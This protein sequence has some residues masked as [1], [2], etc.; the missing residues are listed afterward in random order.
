MIRKLLLA[1]AAIF[2]GKKVIAAKNRQGGTAFA[3]ATPR[4]TTG[5]HV[6]TDLMGDTHPGF[7]QRAPE[8]FRPDPHAPSS[9]EEREAMRPVTLPLRS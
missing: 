8:A 9:P 4:A 3:G 6:P 2:V 7:D 5:E 1:A